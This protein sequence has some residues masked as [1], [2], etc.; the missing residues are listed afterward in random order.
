MSNGDYDVFVAA[1]DPSYID[2]TNNFD[3]EGWIV[4]DPDGEDNFDEY[5]LTV[6]VSDGRLTFQP[7]AGASNSKICFIEITSAP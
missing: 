5:S 3:I 6:T 7:A 4:N 2:Q 1:G